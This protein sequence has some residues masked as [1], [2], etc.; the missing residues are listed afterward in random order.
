[1]ISEL[2]ENSNLLLHFFRTYVKMICIMSHGR[3]ERK[4]FGGYIMNTLELVFGIVII[5]LGAILVAAVLAQSGKDKKLSGAIA[6]SA[7]TFY[8]KQKANTLDRILARVTPIL[9]IVFTIL[10][11]VVSF[12]VGNM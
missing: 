11:V 6:G 2:S 10:V 8:S 4:L 7:D 1:M 12:Y 9:A 5:V 3:F